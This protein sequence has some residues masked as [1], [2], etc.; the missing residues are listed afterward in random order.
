MLQWKQWDDNMATQ[1]ERISV[2]ET[3][4]ESLTEKVDDLKVSINDTKISL[5][6]K[7]DEM[8]A[9]SCS[10]HASLAE[11]LNEV[12]KFKDKWLYV[13]M[14]GLAVLGWVTGHLDLIAKLLN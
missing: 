9:A 6:D 12:E 4:V 3:K 13:S 1:A 8:Y 14:G 10:Q 11:K 7:L 2:V 5:T